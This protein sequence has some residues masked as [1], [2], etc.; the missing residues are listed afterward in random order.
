MSDL[1]TAS[2]RASSVQL[3]QP[4]LNS[5]PFPDGTLDQGD[6]QHI[7]HTY[8]GILAGGF[9]PPPVSAG[10]DYIIRARRRGRR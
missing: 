8:S 1:D 7:A 4:G 10:D 5:P 9:V 6:Q 3:L 2:K